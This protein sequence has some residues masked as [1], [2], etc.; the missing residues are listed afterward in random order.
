MIS[1]DDL[2]LIHKNLFHANN[3]IQNNEQ[4]YIDFC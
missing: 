4:V 1:Q 2:F 3:E